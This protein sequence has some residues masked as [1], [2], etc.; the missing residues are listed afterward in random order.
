MTSPSLTPGVLLA[1]AQQAAASAQALMALG[2]ADGACNRAYYAMFDAARAVLLV[3]GHPTREGGAKTHSGVIS[4]FSL[5]LVKTGQVPMSLGR[6]LKRA[7]ETR[8]VADYRGDSVTG[9]EAS[10]LVLQ[11]QEFVEAMLALCE[12]GAGEP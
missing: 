4:A 8:V 6:A 5:Q 10:A 11:A 12:S 2:D 7:E 9:D 3:H 1:K